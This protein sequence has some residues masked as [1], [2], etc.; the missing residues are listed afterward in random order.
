MAT[1]NGIKPLSANDVG[2]PRIPAPRIAA[3]VTKS[4]HAHRLIQ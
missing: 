4:I 2:R 3:I 1:I